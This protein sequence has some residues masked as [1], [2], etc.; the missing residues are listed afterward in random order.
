MQT[1]DP[2]VTDEKPVRRRVRAAS[3]EAEA[4]RRR[5]AAKR[6]GSAE[7]DAAQPRRRTRRKAEEPAEASVSPA[8]A[9]AAPPEQPRAEEPRPAPVREA[10]PAAAVETPQRAEAREASIPASPAPGRPERTQ[11]VETEGGSKSPSPE[12]FRG[13]DGEGAAGGSAAPSPAAASAP[14]ATAAPAPA[15]HAPG[16]PP[17]ANRHGHRQE[18]FRSRHGR[19]G[20]GQ[21]GQGGQPRPP[22]AEGAQGTP[23]AQAAAGAQASTAGQPAPQP[24]H[25]RRRRRR[26][27]GHG[28]QAQGAAAAGAEPQQTVTGVLEMDERGFGRLRRTDKNFLAA[29]ADPEVSKQIVDRFKL[30]PGAL[31]TGAGIVRNGRVLVQKVDQVEGTTPDEAANRLTFPNLTVIDPTRR[32]KL[33]TTSGELLTRVIDLISPIG[34]GQRGLIVASPKTGKT[35][36]LQKIAK[37]VLTNHPKAKLIVL[38]IDE[39]PEEVTDFRRTIGAEVYASSSDRAATEHLRLSEMALERARRM[40]EN[41]DD[42][43]ILLDSLTRVARAFN[44]EAD[45]SGRTMSGGVDSRALERPKRMFGSAR[46][47]EEAGSLTMMATALIDTGS[48]MDEV[49]FEEFKGTGNLE[50]VLDRQLAERRLWPAVNVNGSGTRKEEKLYGPKENEKIRKLRA[51]LAA[52]RPVDAMEKLLSRLKD[53]RSNA[54]FLEAM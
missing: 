19:H 35:I 25:G 31:V 49:I 12:L 8:E 23:G 3:E 13:R 1:K 27:R 17:P 5:P 22:A 43:V 10:S 51:Y 28:A 24:G 54:E 38:L 46:N 40:V 26:G 29:D 32:I 34:F 21:P 11:P 41:G 36:I 9:P 14:E 7:E 50:L 52:L 44:K 53:F 16:A 4:P 30:R 45:S 6:N 37:A 48:R 33:E 15:A 39:R 42:V 2:T 18:R 20:H 47:T